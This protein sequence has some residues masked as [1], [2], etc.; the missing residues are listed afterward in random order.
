MSAAQTP[1]ILISGI[2]P[3]PMTALTI[4][5]QWDLPD[6]VVVHHE[7]DID[8]EILI[9]TISDQHGL[10]QRR[11]ISL[12]HACVSCAIRGDVV[13]T[14]EYLAAKG[15]W[16][17]IIAQLPETAE[18]AQVCRAIGYDPK[19]APHARISAALVAM[20][21]VSVAEDLLGDDLLV[22]RG[23]PVRDDDE[24]GVG[25]TAASLVEYA[26]LVVA[27]GLTP[28][29]RSLLQA[30]M[31]PGVPVVDAAAEVDS[32]ALLVG[33]HHH[34][35]SEDWVQVIRREPLT[36]VSTEA[37]WQLDL[38]SDRP[39]HPERLRQRIEDLGRG[40]RRSRGCFWL[41]TRPNQV[42]QWDGAGGM[43]SIGVADD[44]SEGDQLTRIVV[45]GTDA[46][47]EELAHAFEDCLLT[48]QEVAER[49]R[50]W[51]VNTDGMEPWLGPVPYLMARGA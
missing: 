17:A 9:R 2:D 25:E 24:R 39:F 44:W 27:E 31:R 35:S 14:L 4:A 7:V 18:A 50:Y 6:A 15:R 41:P 37:A 20:D 47:R 49:G 36:G 46:G 1:V 8:A 30:L 42:C 28:D 38:S 23:L 10:I 40:R 48:D 16:G 3:E 32:A 13:P 5:L 12:A 51:E 33:P 34:E 43:V 26:D 11:E 21:G 29:G 45:V 19:A 22:E